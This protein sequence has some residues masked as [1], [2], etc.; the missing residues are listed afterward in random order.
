[1]DTS[2]EQH[3]VNIKALGQETRG[4]TPTTLNGS[5][6]RS[7]ATVTAQR[8]V[9]LSA[10][11]LSADLHGFL[12]GPRSKSRTIATPS[13]SAD[14][15]SGGARAEEHRLRN[16]ADPT[17]QGQRRRTIQGAQ[18]RGKRRDSTCLLR[19][20]RSRPEGHGAE[21]PL[22]VAFTPAPIL[23]CRN[24]GG[25]RLERHS[26]EGQR[27]YHDGAKVDGRTRQ[28]IRA[29]APSRVAVSRSPRTS[30]ASSQSSACIPLNR[31]GKFGSEIQTSSCL[32]LKRRGKF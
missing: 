29:R 31:C 8:R 18:C 1:V 7:R 22:L 32:P 9:N 27:T 10:Y 16:S 25:T 6:W 15:S 23:H 21:R 12:P 4:L 26:A 17:P 28:N 24:S 2:V 30:P 3:S 14:P 19:A 11:H 5:V 20:P 13:S